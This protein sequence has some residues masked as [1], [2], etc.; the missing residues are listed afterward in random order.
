MGSTYSLHPGFQSKINLSLS[1]LNQQGLVVICGPSGCGK[2]HLTAWLHRQSRFADHPIMSLEAASLPM[3]R[4][5]SELFGHVKGAFTGAVQTYPGLLGM[6]NKGI[7]VLESIEDL[8][9]EGQARL[10]RFIETKSYR[11]VGGLG[12][13]PYPGGLMMTSRFSLAALFQK[14]VLREDFYFR[15][16]GHDLLMP[17]PQVRKTDFASIFK[18][19]TSA[20]SNE[21]GHADNIFTNA[22]L[23]DCQNRQL[24]GGYHELRNLLFRAGIMGRPTAELTLEQTTPDACELPNSGTLKQDLALVEKALILRALEQF[25]ES[26]Q[27]LA[28]HLGLSLRSL[29][30][31]LQRYNLV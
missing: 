7:F 30:Y 22:D 3:A 6:V 13:I 24:L 28:K 26:R 20:V 25:P 27:E 2:T 15:L 9:Q 19:L 4:F 5:E 17:A 21:L 8:T 31:K 23:Q 12:D 16:V 1:Q 18:T 29:Q 10:L 11:A 14:N